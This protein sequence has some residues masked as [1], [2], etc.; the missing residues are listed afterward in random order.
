[1]NAV[2]DS[3]SSSK[4]TLYVDLGRN[5]LKVLNVHTPSYAAQMINV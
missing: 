1:M 2:R 5:W 3:W 4:A